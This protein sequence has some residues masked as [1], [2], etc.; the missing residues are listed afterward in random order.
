MHDAQNECMQKSDTVYEY[1][2]S[3]QY[4]R[5]SVSV[6]CGKF[7]VEMPVSVCQWKFDAWNVKLK[8][9]LEYRRG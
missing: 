7:S 4:V 6:Q 9:L 3:V 5:C 2:V 8:K 1:S